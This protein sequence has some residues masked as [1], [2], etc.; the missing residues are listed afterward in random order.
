MQRGIKVEG[1]GA[2]N[3]EQGPWGSRENNTEVS[4]TVSK[5]QTFWLCGYGISIFA[6]LTLFWCPTFTWDMERGWSRRQRRTEWPRNWRQGEGRSL[7][8]AI[9]CHGLQHLCFCCSN[10]V[11]TPNLHFRYKE[12][13]KSKVTEHWTANM[14]HRVTKKTTPKWAKQF[15]KCKLFGHA[16]ATFPFLLL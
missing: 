16:A 15:E 5:M 1:N 12:G 11:S 2:L 14:V 9:F 10:L 13:S 8:N 3:G 7:K 6:A 4:S